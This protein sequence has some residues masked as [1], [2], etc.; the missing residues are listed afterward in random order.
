MLAATLLSIHNL[1]TL[2]RLVHEI[3]QAIVDQRLVTF[4]NGYLE[5]KAKLGE[6]TPEH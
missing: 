4:L 3:R 5:I 2:I 1:H 6:S